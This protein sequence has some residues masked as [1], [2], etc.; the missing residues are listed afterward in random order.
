MCDKTIVHSKMSHVDA[1]HSMAHETK[2]VGDI[3]KDQTDAKSA[4]HS[5]QNGQSQTDLCFFD[6]L[7]ISNSAT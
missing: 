4:Y 5:R 1:T 3:K 7:T 6:L 2:S